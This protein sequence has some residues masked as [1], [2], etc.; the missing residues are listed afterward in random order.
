MVRRR[1]LLLG[2]RCTEVTHCA[3]LI[4]SR[5]QE[6]LPRA[7]SIGCGVSVLQERAG[8]RSRATERDL[9]QQVAAAGPRDRLK[10]P[11]KHFEVA[12]DPPCQVTV[13]T[14]EQLPEGTGRRDW[15][16]CGLGLHGGFL[17]TV[18]TGRWWRRAEVMSRW[19]SSCPAPVL[20]FEIDIGRRCREQAVGCPGPI[21]SPGCLQAQRDG[22]RDMRRCHACARLSDEQTGLTAQPSGADLAASMLTPGA[23][24]SGL[25]RLSRVGPALLK[26]GHRRRRSRGRSTAPTTRGSLPLA[27]VPI[28][29]VATLIAGV[30]RAWQR[31][32]RSSR[33]SHA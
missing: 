2:S 30:N 7:Q 27:I 3:A 9:E 4:G 1:G 26:Q 13:G 10:R 6:E 22:T 15:K 31:G 18:G 12:F 29:P 14:V 19:I 20:V 21:A 25:M 16:R 23:T 8:S 24:R 28:V 17:W 32:Q 5:A 11:S 33:S